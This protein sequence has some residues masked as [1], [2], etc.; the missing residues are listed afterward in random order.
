MTSIS[1][2]VL[3]TDIKQSDKKISVDNESVHDDIEEKKSYGKLKCARIQ[4]EL[5]CI[6]EK[7]FDT[8]TNKPIIKH[9]NRILK[10]A[11]KIV[12][13]D[14]CDLYDLHKNID[15]VLHEYISEIKNYE[16]VENWIN[17]YNIC[18][19][20]FN[21]VNLKNTSEKDSK[22]TPEKKELIKE[23]KKNIIINSLYKII[24]KESDIV[25][26]DLS[27]IVFKSTDFV[28]MNTMCHNLSTLRHTASG[29]ENILYILQKQINNY[30]LVEQWLINYKI[31]NVD[32]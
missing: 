22:L 32:S 13:I 14:L 12:E 21:S 2:Q 19:T 9:L 1:T 25:L 3:T 8:N 5:L 10:R 27:S 16:L 30:D 31:Y 26:D 7:L 15:S 20:S 18:N 24:L 4:S 29:C 11:T 6:I 28:D 17:E 23:S